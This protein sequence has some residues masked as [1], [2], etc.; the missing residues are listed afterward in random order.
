MRHA[1]EIIK[2]ILENFPPVVD[3]IFLV[4]TLAVTV[5]GAIK[6]AFEIPDFVKDWKDRLQHKK[7]RVKTSILKFIVDEDKTQLIKLR[8]VRAHEKL[9]RLVLDPV[10][11]YGPGAIIVDRGARHANDYS[12]PGRTSVVPWEGK[13]KFQIDFMTDEQLAPRSDHSILLS[14]VLDEKVDVLFKPPEVQAIQPVGSERLVIEVYFPPKWKLKPNSTRVSTVNP[15][16]GEEGGALAES[17]VTVQPYRFDF[18]DGRGEI[19]WI[20]AVI[21]KPPQDYDISLKWDWEKVP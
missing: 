6:A 17:R 8:T 16:T 4:L 20:R 19:D 18:S 10:P 2:Y 1:I 11:V 13:N 14:Y 21:R 3:F 15:T 5:Y 12:V 7:Y 9:D